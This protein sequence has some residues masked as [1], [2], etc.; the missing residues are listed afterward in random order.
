[1]RRRA[2]TSAW[3]LADAGSRGGVGVA[4]VAGWTWLDAQQRCTRVSRLVSTSSFN[5][6]PPKTFDWDWDDD[7]KVTKLRTR[8]RNALAASRGAIA[9]RMSSGSSA[10]PS[11]DSTV[12]PVNLG[13]FTHDPPPW[14]IRNANG[15]GMNSSSSPLYDPL[16]FTSYFKKRP[17]KL[18]K[19]FT[20]IML[21]LCD[22]GVRV[23]LKQGTIESRAERLKNHFSKLGPAFVKLGQVLSTRS[24]FLPK[25]YCDQLTMLQENIEPASKTHAVELLTRE[26]GFADE[27]QIDFL[28]RNGLPDAPIAAASLAQVYKVELS[29]A[30][31]KSSNGSNSDGSPIPTTPITL[32][33]KIQRPGL[34]EQVALD[35]VILRGIAIVLRNVIK[36]RSDVVGIVD[37]LVGR[38]FGELSYY[39][40]L[41][42]VERFREIYAKNG[43]SGPELAGKV[44]APRV[45]PELSTDQVLVMEWVDGVRLTD[46]EGIE[47]ILGG[48]IGDDKNDN[49]K[50]KNSESSLNRQS[51]LLLE[52]G[53]RCSLHQLLETGF[54]H[55]DPHPGNLVVCRKTGSL[56]YLDFGMTVEVTPERRKAMIRGLVGFVNKDATSLI[57]D[58]VEL[59]FLPKDV[60]R[61]AATDALSKVF[62]GVSEGQS[63]TDTGDLKGD[64]SVSK[65]SQVRSTNDFLGVVSQLGAALFE[66]EFRLP[67]YFSRI[68]RA[69]ASLEGVA[70]SVDPS[71]RVIDRVY[72][73]VLQSLVKDPDPET[74]KIL[75]RL[76]LEDDGE[77][78]RWRRVFRI[79]GAIADGAGPSVDR[80]KGAFGAFS[81]SSDKESKRWDTQRLKRIA[82]GVV[83]TSVGVAE[84]ASEVARL[85]L[86]STRGTDCSTGSTLGTSSPGTLA[87]ASAVRDAMEYVTSPAGA[88][89]RSALVKDALAASDEVLEATELHHTKD[90][91]IGSTTTGSKSQSKSSDQGTP[92]LSFETVCSYANAGRRVYLSAPKVWAPIVADVC[93]K[94]ETADTLTELLVGL[95]TRV[96]SKN[97]RK[98][99]KALVRGVG[100]AI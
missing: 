82:C 39:D 9:D 26:L 80:E 88:N 85:E 40:E 76:I 11:T 35:A 33:L 68:L 69:L 5:Q 96:N 8:V 22:V 4:D 74:R 52:R 95:S 67:P 37:E 49:D 58:L 32:A 60:D 64:S 54:M 59:E 21:R 23:A 77:R 71:F 7:E 91:S 50:T 2:A 75:K 84:G 73:Y 81:D 27:G 25:S 12:Q 47:K 46:V 78:I 55:A 24:D 100:E 63:N 70:T 44:R 86:C 45:I 43:N 38:I 19:R 13:W 18:V 90:D 16:L 51:H 62:E 15:N 94:P 57:H 3:R 20:E 30:F 17:L 36:L 87:A 41:Q 79:L 83:E 10:S 29:N 65:T 14:E 92:P 89:L 61:I 56:T 97:A 6:S 1:M 66:F 34:A 42:S 99:L 53:V 48:R 31:L 93:R 72:P 28:F 98:V